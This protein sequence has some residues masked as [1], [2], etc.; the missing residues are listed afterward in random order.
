MTTQSFEEA[1]Q[2]FVERSREMLE[3]ETT[4]SLP[5]GPPSPFRQD[6]PPYECAIRLDERTIRNYVRTIGENN[7]LYTDPAYAKSSKYGCLTIPGPF[8]SMVRGITAHGAQSG[9]AGRQRPGGYPVANFFSGTA[10]EFFD[11]LRIGSKF[12]SSMVTKEL[13]EKPG[14]RGNLMF[15]ISELLLLGRPRRPSRQVLRHPH[16]GPHRDHGHVAHHARRA[17]RRK[18]ALRPQRLQ[19]LPGRHPAPTRRRGER[20]AARHQYSLLGRRGDRR[21]TRS[22]GHPALD[23][24]GLRRTPRSRRGRPWLGGRPRR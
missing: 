7:P 23:A 8:L 1:I 10:W 9:E 2:E 16:H 21:E 12:N 5:P 4:E 14:S 17:P 19:L 18:A 20:E 22:N 13:I 3:Q 15:F 24:P 6:G 11:V